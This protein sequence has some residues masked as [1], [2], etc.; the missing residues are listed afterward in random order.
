MYK[1]HDQMNRGPQLDPS[2]D[3]NLSVISC[4]LVHLLRKCMQHLNSTF[5][6]S[7]KR[8]RDLGEGSS[9][10]VTMLVVEPVDS[11]MM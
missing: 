1:L 7:Q 10:T 8:C 6:A 4:I 2:S 11:V 3:F 5:A 9:A